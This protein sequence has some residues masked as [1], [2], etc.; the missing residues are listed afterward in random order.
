[1]GEE[2]GEK[3]RLTNPVV[4]PQPRNTPKDDNVP[5]SKHLPSINQSADH[6]CN[7]NITQQDQPQLALLVE[8][9]ILAEVEMRDLRSSCT[10]IFLSCQVKQEVSRPA[11][12]LMN[13]AMPQAGNWG[14]LCQFRE[15]NQVR[16]GFGTKVPLNPCL[17]CVWDES[18]VFIHVAGVL[19]VLGVRDSPGVE[20]NE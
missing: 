3:K 6:S 5:A 8:D 12:K 15:F 14:I 1:M 13:D 9:R 16:L 2:R 7:T 17:A 10:T 20:G 4:N 19:V 18:G 11:E